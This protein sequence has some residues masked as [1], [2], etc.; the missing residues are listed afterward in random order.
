MALPEEFHFET[1]Y[2]RIRALQRKG[3]A[4]EPTAKLVLNPDFKKK[5]L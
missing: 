3:F 2:L 5:L 1:I 4:K